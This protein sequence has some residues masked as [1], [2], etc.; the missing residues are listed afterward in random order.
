MTSHKYIKFDK[1]MHGVAVAWFVISALLTIIYA[2][3]GNLHSAQRVFVQLLVVGGF[4]FIG[5]AR[6]AYK[7]F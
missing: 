6:G 4:Y 5:R 1:V 7:G 2:V 3:I